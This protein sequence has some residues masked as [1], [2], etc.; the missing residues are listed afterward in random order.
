MSTGSQPAR[1]ALLWTAAALGLAVIV[2]VIGFDVVRRAAKMQAATSS[3]AA[4][5]QAQP[6]KKIKVVVRLSGPA[7]PGTYTGR[8][9]E[10]AD[11][12]VYHATPATIRIVYG[13]DTSVV[14]GG[15]AD[16]KAG[17][18]LEA[19]GSMEDADTLRASQVVIL[20]GFVQIATGG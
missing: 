17:A 13:D 15:A 19:I 8:V 4:V 5:K 14:M 6:G 9:L 12:S 1:R 20:N 7:S 11:G 3:V 16:I 2:G 18:I 10:S